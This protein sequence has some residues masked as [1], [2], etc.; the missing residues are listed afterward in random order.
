MPQ[1]AAP[2]DGEQDGRCARTEAAPRPAKR[3]LEIYDAYDNP[4]VLYETFDGAELVVGDQELLIGFGQLQHMIRELSGWFGV[5]SLEQLLRRAAEQVEQARG[6]LE[7]WARSAK[8]FEEYRRILRHTDALRD[9]EQTLAAI[10][11]GFGLSAAGR[12]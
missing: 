3:R 11:D 10:Q 5:E 7:G 2:E 1:T 9:I 6:E 12:A 4:V 8:Y